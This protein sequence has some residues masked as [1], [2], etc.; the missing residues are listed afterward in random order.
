MDCKHCSKPCCKC[1]KQR[2][3]K[4][5]YR[6]KNCFKYQQASYQNQAYDIDINSQITSMAKEGVSIRSIGRLLSISKNTVL[7]RIR[8]IVASIK[9]PEIKLGSIYELDEMW[10]F[11]QSKNNQQWIS[12]IYDRSTKTVVDFVVGR[13]S[14]ELSRPIVS[15]VFRIAQN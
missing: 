3:G 15:E 6:C 14:R 8:L 1:G 13:R 10:T 4:Q 11:S 12:Y 9:K 5:K 7:R 2:N